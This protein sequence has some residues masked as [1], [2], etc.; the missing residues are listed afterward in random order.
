MKTKRLLF[1]ISF[2]QLMCIKSLTHAQDFF[3]HFPVSASVNF[4]GTQQRLVCTVYDSVLQTTVSYNTPWAP[5]QI[6]ITGNYNGIL[7]YTFW[8]SPGVQAPKMEFLIYD[9]LIHQFAVHTITLPN[10]PNYKS[11]IFAGPIWVDQYHETQSGSWYSYSRQL[12]RYNLIY[13]KWI[14]ISV[15]V[16]NEFGD[17]IDI[18]S[19]STSTNSEVIVSSDWDNYFDHL[20][21]NPVHDS[22]HHQFSGCPFSH[23]ISDDYLV[24][25]GSCASDYNF[26]VFEPIQN[27]VLKF[28]VHDHMG[29]MNNG[30]FIAIDEHTQ[31]FGY[32]FTYDQELQSWMIDTLWSYKWWSHSISERVV[33]YQSEDGV[34]PPK[35]YFETYDPHIKAWAKDSVVVFGAVT[36]L[37]VINGTVSWNDV[38]GLHEW[39]YDTVTGWGNYNTQMLLD[40][41]LTDFTSLGFPGIHV[42]NYSIQRSDLFYDFGDG[43]RT[44]ANKLVTW[45][46]YKDP[47]TYNVCLY[48]SDSLY[49]VCKQVTI[50]S[51]PLSG[52]ISASTDTICTADAVQ[53][54]TSTIPGNIQ[55][56][57]KTGGMWIDETGPGA[58]D[59]V[60]SVNPMQSESYRIKYSLPGC[61]SGFS[62]QI[63]I[64]VY[65]TLVNVVLQDTLVNLCVGTTTTLKVLNPPTAN[66][67]WQILSG[68]N[69]LNAP[70]NST[71]WQFPVSPLI[72]TMYRVIMTSGVC[73]SETLYVNVNVLPIPVAPVVSGD[74]SCGPGTVTLSASGAGTIDWY[75]SLTSELLSNGTSFSPFVSTTTDYVAVTSTGVNGYGGYPDSTIGTV[76]AH[77]SEKFGQRFMVDF[78]ARLHSVAVYPQSTG[79]YTFKLLYGGTNQVVATKAINLI[80][81]TG[82]T[83]IPL[84]F[85]L[86]TN[87]IYDLIITGGPFTMDISSSGITYPFTTLNNSLTILG[88]LDSTVYSQNPDYYGFYDWHLTT[89]C[90]SN[91]TTVPVVVGTPF[92]STI[93]A[94]GPLTFCQ[95]QSVTLNVQPTG[96]GYHYKWLNHNSIISGANSAAFVVH[97]TGSYK[98]I[99]DNLGCFD[100]TSF[101]RVTVPCLPPTDADEKPYSDTQSTSTITSVYYSSSDALAVHANVI[102]QGRLDYSVID[103][104]GRTVLK[105]FSPIVEGDNV[106]EIPCNYFTQG[107]YLLKVTFNR[108]HYNLKFMK[109]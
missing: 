56:Q 55:W 51:C 62:N 100:T 78:S 66:Y 30:V 6:V 32:C 89:G 54:S 58:T 31:N 39:G 49:S 16:Y 53:L 75:Q 25:D 23:Y 93:S 79:N 105:G 109:N 9:Y 48:T 10:Y 19:P 85:T 46:A 97:S 14:S 104:S 45:H 77:S 69:W 43:T 29:E 11:N 7:T 72:S 44:Q 90:Y 22:I 103:F 83:I 41:Q 81:G 59:T 101:I 24:V 50:N 1:L 35:V 84:N 21:Y 2:L 3:I 17:Q 5:E 12:Y 94:S 71:N 64:K 82:K 88:Y 102:S 42:R 13:H 15:R 38:N 73:A 70:G 95:G 47:G 60:Y 4:N 108:M 86:E 96:N 68:A 106:V 34:V 40:F 87:V 36:G 76:V 107:I 67:Q 26:S 52:I 98:A 28:P 91:P 65:P 37:S 8:T 33:A 27:K 57:R 74:S 63:D 20:Y 80:A 61:V 92:S 18:F 99:V